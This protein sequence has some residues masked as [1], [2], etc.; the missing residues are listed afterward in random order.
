MGM[1][2]HDV[3]TFPLCPS[4][5]TEFDQGKSYTKEQRRAL[6]DEWVLLT[7]LDLASSGKVAP[8]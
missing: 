4:C 5:H 8:K 2:A 1:K 3:W 7:I 6:A